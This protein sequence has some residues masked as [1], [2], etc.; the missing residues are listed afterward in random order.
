VLYW[1]A[2]HFQMLDPRKVRSLVE[3]VGWPR[4]AFLLS[5]ALLAARIVTFEQ[6]VILLLIALVPAFSK[7]PDKRRGMRE[8]R[9]NESAQKEQSSDGT[10]GVLETS[11][12]RAPK[13]S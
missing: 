1:E 6:C 4:T 12:R 13:V 11:P 5:M 7:H 9:Q 10:D 8:H 3:T 2:T